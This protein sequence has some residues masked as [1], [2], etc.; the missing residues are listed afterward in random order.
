MKKSHLPQVLNELKKFDYKIMVVLHKS[1]IETIESIKNYDV[2]IAFQKD[3]GY[4]DALST[5][6]KETNMNYFVY[7]MLMDHLN[8]KN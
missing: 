5:G 8:L 7:L 1:D 4:G 3:F 6:I 2:K